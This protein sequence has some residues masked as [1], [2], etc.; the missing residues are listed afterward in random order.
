[1]CPWSATSRSP[2]RRELAR[3]V[4]HADAAAAPLEAQQPFGEREAV[5]RDRG[6]QGVALEVV[7]A[8]H[9]VERRRQPGEHVEGLG[10]GDVPG[11]DHALDAR[12]V[13][14]LDD[15]AHVREMIV[16]VAHYA[17]AH[18]PTLAARRPRRL[19]RGAP[20][21]AAQRRRWQA[22]VL[23]RLRSPSPKRPAERP[24]ARARPLQP[25][26]VQGPCREGCGQLWAHRT[27]RLR[28][29]RGDGR[30]ARAP[31]ETC[32]PLALRV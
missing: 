22:G 19:A 29:R 17:D 32:L 5:A 6:A 10:L 23:L 12:R 2:A 30:G 21:P 3:I 20:G 13:Q 4:H 28:E 31:R 18:A 14:E 27:P 24:P 26:F 1:M 8:E 9:A 25:A 15:A 11:M 7:V 16:G